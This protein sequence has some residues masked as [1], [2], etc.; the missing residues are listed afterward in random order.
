M[1]KLT[2]LAVLALTFSPAIASAH[3][4]QSN[5]TRV[6]PNLFHDRSPRLHEHTI[7]FHEH[8]P[9]AHH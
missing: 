2:I 4:V 8:T 6:R 7:S 3:P 9:V 5:G 1:N